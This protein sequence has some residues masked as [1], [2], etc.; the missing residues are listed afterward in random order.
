MTKQY[1]IIQ[2]RYTDGWDNEPVQDEYPVLFDSIERARERAKSGTET[3]F[4]HKGHAFWIAELEPYRDGMT[5]T[6]RQF[7]L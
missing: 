1:Q 3:M 2:E 6:G 4:E 7:P 5:Y